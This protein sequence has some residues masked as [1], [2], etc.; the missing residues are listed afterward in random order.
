M[1]W[2]PVLVFVVAAASGMSCARP[3]KPDARPVVVDY[4]SPPASLDPANPSEEVSYSILGNVYETL[5]ERDSQLKLRPGLAEEWHDEDEG[6]T[7]V[8]RIRSGV[9]FHDG[10]PLTARDIADSFSGVSGTV[11]RGRGGLEEV[12]R[13]ETPDARTLRV[14]TKEPI[15]DLPHYLAS[16]FVFRPP[17]EPGGLPVGTGPYEIARRGPD[18]ATYL[19][20]FPGYRTPAGVKALEFH[21]VP[22]EAERLARLERGDSHVLNDVPSHAL[23]RL[24]ASPRTRIQVTRGLRVLL[25]GIDMRGEPA[26][27]RDDRVRLAIARA[28]DY[29]ALVDG[30]L[31]GHGATTGQVVSSAVAG[32]APDI[33]PLG[34]DLAESRRLLSAAGLGA[35]VEVTLEYMPARYRAIEAVANAIAKDLSKAG[36]VVALKP[37]EVAEFLERRQ[38]GHGGL[39]LQG[40]MNT[41]W[42]AGATYE[43]LLHTRAGRQG[44]A[45]G[46]GYSNPEVDQAIGA[47]RRE[48][49]LER[50][51]GIYRSLALRVQKDLPLIPLYLQ[52]DLWAL[53]GQLEFEPTVTREI[54]GFR[55]KWR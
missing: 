12:E 22:E 21:V 11:A 3:K 28:I 23:A 5:L 29:E 54:R 36:F 1:R 55:M 40:W 15:V 44:S 52:D 47:A 35:G 37:L 7:W 16:L 46:T 9:S 50:R 30:P 18:G 14:R 10:Q 26:A 51:I 2:R 38:T 42:D 17:L 39:F 25:L 45:N 49:D 20:A 48:L 53:A 31:G 27:L 19:A 8:F 33:G 4:P 34:S 32:Y 24:A 13:F 41:G 43:Q 6:R